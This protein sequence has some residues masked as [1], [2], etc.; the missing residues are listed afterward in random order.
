MSPFL[1]LPYMDIDMNYQAIMGAYT[2]SGGVI[3]VS[4]ANDT[5]SLTIRDMDTQKVSELK[6]HELDSLLFWLDGKQLSLTPTLK[7]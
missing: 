5:L 2:N 7:Q 4:K 1:A 3:A 6:D